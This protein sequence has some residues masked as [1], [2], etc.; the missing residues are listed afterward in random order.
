MF[1]WIFFQ[2][3]GIRWTETKV[4]ACNYGHY[5]SGILIFK[6]Q[7][8][9]KES[10]LTSS[11]PQLRKPVG[12]HVLV[13]GFLQRVRFLGFLLERNLHC[14]AV[15][16]NI[17]TLLSACLKVL[18]KKF[19][20][21]L[22]STKGITRTRGAHLENTFSLCEMCSYFQ[23][24]YARDCIWAMQGAF[25]LCESRSTVTCC[26]TTDANG[27]QWGTCSSSSRGPHWW[28]CVMGGEVRGSFR[29]ERGRILAA[30]TCARNPPPLFEHYSH[31][32]SS[33]TYA[34]KMAGMG[35]REPI[36]NWAAYWG[37][38]WIF[39]LVYESM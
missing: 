3:S 16:L 39:L 23:R 15:S 26:K 35:L 7:I 22:V 33:Q 24:P 10:T 2:T 5:Y 11:F 17:I 8:F 20:S 13:A 19:L 30:A 31:L 36:V 28:R 6:T 9:L 1:K 34:S 14:S 38:R 29:T 12:W 25:W 21:T 4:L 32:S 27:Q 18:K 37:V